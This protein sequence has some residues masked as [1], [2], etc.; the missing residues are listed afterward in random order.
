MI[1]T[2]ECVRG[3][4]VPEVKTGKTQDGEPKLLG[5]WNWP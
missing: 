4:D 1:D 3:E 5:K 2:Q